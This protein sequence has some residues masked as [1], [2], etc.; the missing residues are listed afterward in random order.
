MG[1][2]LRLHYRDGKIAGGDG[3]WQVQ[4]KALLQRDAAV[5]VRA[6]VRARTMFVVTTMLALATAGVF[7]AMIA[8]LHG[9]G[10]S[11]HAVLMMNLTVP[12][13][14]QMGLRQTGEERQQAKNG[15][16]PVCDHRFNMVRNGGL[17]NRRE[18]RASLYSA[19]RRYIVVE[20]RRVM[21]STV[22]VRAL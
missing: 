21:N 5:H 8:P 15:E 1:S 2:G 10:Q 11:R 18:T 9:V 14:A 12:G 19:R 22:R 6:V 4:R 7:M 20:H 13:G 3:G 17:G 16:Y